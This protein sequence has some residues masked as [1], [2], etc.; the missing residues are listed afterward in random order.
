[1]STYSDIARRAAAFPTLVLA[2]SLPLVA[3]AGLDKRATPGGAASAKARGAAVGQQLRCWQYGR[4]IFE[5]NGIVAPAESASYALRMHADDASRTPVL[6]VNTGSA[7]CLIKGAA[8][9]GKP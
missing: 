1:M 8:A 4:L 6:L 5:E 3:A 2:L 7:T 9:A